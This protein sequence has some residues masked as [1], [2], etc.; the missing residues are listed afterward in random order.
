MA[1]TLLGYTIQRGR[2][3][4]AMLSAT[5]SMWICHNSHMFLYFRR[6]KLHFI[7][8]RSIFFS[9]CIEYLN[10]TD[11]RLFVFFFF[12]HIVIFSD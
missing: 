5:L 3:S 10:L 11:S 4:E 7:I 2:E 8:S 1:Q 12:L 9:E 6:V